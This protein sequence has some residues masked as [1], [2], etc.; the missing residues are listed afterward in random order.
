MPDHHDGIST[1]KL[2]EQNVI[3]HKIQHVFIRVGTTNVNFS[4]LIAG[5]I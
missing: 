3:M 4:R 2:E 1:R 5:K